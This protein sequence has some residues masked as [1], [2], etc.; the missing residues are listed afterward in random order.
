MKRSSQQA[1]SQY[2]QVKG[3]AH[4][5]SGIAGEESPNTTGRGGS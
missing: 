2:L 3:W 4:D 5:R 1:V